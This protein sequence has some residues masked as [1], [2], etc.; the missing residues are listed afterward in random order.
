MEGEIES[1]FTLLQYQ[2]MVCTYSKK[3]DSPPIF[4]EFLKVVDRI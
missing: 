1:N 4:I 3:I 2:D